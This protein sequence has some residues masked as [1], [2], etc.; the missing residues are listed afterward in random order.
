MSD[1]SRRRPWLAALLAFTPFVYE[2]AFVL[3]AGRAGVGSPWQHVLST[4]DLLLFV[5]CLVL[6][7]IPALVAYRLT[8]G[9]FVPRI[10]AR[11][12]A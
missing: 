8:T 4:A 1:R 12:G 11:L 10:R 9:A 6:A 3:E 2:L 5:L 7:A